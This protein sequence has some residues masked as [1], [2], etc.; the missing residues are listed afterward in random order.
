MPLI[1]AGG[2][3]DSFDSINVLYCEHCD[4]AY[5]VSLQ[6]ELQPLSMDEWNALLASIRA[7]VA[8]EHDEGH[9]SYVFYHDGQSLQTVAVLEKRG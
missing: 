9:P 3:C 7:D 4:T 5:S 2:A 6:G 8:I 1:M